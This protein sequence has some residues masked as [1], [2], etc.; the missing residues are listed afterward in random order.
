MSE[1]AA[2]LR[3][4]PTIDKATD[5]ELVK[6]FDLDDVAELNGTAAGK[7]GWLMHQVCD[8][9]WMKYEGE[10]VWTFQPDHDEPELP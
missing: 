7:H 3:G 2:N 5:D 9:Q 1:P 10:T 8:G 4:V 6:L